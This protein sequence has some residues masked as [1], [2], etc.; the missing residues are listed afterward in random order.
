MK[1][2]HLDEVPD[3]KEVKAFLNAGEYK[4]KEVNDLEYLDDVLS[5]MGEYFGF[6]AKKQWRKKMALKY[7]EYYFKTK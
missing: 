7:Q 2:Y 6:K 3:F 1:V 5:N 4:A